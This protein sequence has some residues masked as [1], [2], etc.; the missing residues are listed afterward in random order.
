MY[1]TFIIVLPF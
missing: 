1:D